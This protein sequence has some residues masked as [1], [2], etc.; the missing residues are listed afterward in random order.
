MTNQVITFSEDDART[1]HFPHHDPLVIE[2]QTANMIVAWILVDNG[3]S[4]NILF[5]AAFEKIGLTTANFSP[6]TSTLYGFSGEAMMLMGQ[7]KLP[8]TM[9]DFSSTGIQILHICCG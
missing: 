5:K 7:L 8:V 1:V 4:V 6:C 2:S 9:G 3:S